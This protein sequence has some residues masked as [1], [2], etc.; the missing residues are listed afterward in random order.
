MSEC[1]DILSQDNK[2]EF[3][4]DYCDW[5]YKMYFCDLNENAASWFVMVSRYLA[6]DIH[7]RYL[8]ARKYC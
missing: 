3:A 4:I 6:G 7:V 2:C 5:V 8:Y 1:A